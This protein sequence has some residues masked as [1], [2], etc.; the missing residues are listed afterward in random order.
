MTLLLALLAAA[1]F[2]WGMYWQI[3]A[4]DLRVQLE[5]VEYSRELWRKEYTGVALEA[6]AYRNHAERC[7]FARDEYSHRPNK[8][9]A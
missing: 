6:Q 8:V 1:C 4:R 3:E 5:N 7:P 9:G 2:V